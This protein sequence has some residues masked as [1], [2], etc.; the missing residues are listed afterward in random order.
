MRG[1]FSRA[2]QIGCRP[3]NRAASSCGQKH[4][5]MGFAAIDSHGEPREGVAVEGMG[6][7]SNRHF[8]TQLFKEWGISLCL[9]RERRCD[10]MVGTLDRSSSPLS[11]ERPH[12]SALRTAPANLDHQVVQANNAPELTCDLDDGHDI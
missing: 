3:R 12:T 10:L 5:H 9:I 8:T 4:G 1:F 11:I 6:W 7:I 2:F